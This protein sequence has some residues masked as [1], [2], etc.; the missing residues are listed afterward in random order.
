MVKTLSLPKVR[1]HLDEVIEQTAQD[2]FVIEKNGDPKAVIM[3]IDEYEDYLE[4]HDE[5]FQQEVRE[6]T[7]EYRAGKARPIEALI[8]ELKHEVSHPKNS[9][10]RP[11]RKKAH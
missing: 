6:S 9:K 8:E 2:V 4:T 5:K 3:S 7:E 10:V 1:D 11:R